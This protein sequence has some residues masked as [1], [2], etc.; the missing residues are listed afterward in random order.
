MKSATMICWE[1]APF[2]VRGG[3]AYA[4]RRLADQLTALGIEITVLLPDW[5]DTPPTQDLSPLLKLRPLKMPAGLNEAPRVIQCSEFCRVAAEAA[6]QI[7][8]NSGSDT[9]IAH[10]D[11]GAVF[12]V[13]RKGKR[14][15]G[16]AVFWLH[17]LYDPP[18]SDLS[19]E[20][21]RLLPSQSLLGSAVIMADIVVTS[22]GILKDARDFEWPGRLRELQKALLV[23][24]AEQRVLT[25]ESLG[26]LPPTPGNSQNGHSLGSN[27]EQ[28]GNLPSRYVLFPCRPA[29]DKGLGIFAEIAKRLRA[30]NITCVTVR[31]PAPKPIP[32]SQEALFHWLPWLTQQEL[33]VAMRN[34]ACTALPSVTEGFG[35]AAAESVSLGV[36]TVYHQVGGH[37]G[38]PALP[39]VR[40]V[41][42][43]MGER[44]QLYRIWSELVGS[45]G[46]AWSVW[47]RHENSLDPLIDRWVEIIRSVV[48]SPTCAEQ[49]NADVAR[50]PIAQEQWGHRL[51]RY[52][53]VPTSP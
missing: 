17:S 38:L 18:V 12:I 27:L 9:V 28:L 8:T 24:A 48:H 22:A 36:A 11:E 15:R 31:P 16:P 23:A 30:D 13:E 3:T 50:Q 35:L 2:R 53:E 52:I 19:N 25:V 29:V 20:H 42:M 6:D 4:I 47:A 39:N 5:L 46:D 14:S 43:T 26:C 33:A 1:F 45:N 41:P 49:K 21:R 34:A 51:L 32:A 7:E 10:S 40:Q 37:H 44:A